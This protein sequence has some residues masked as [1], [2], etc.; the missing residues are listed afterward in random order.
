MLESWKEA[1]KQ[2]ERLGVKV[3]T[4][5]RVTDIDAEGVCLGDERIAAKT[6][7]WAAGVAASPIARTLGVPLDKA[8]RVLVDATLQVPGHDEIYIVGDL[9]ALQQDGKPVPGVSPAAMQG[10]RY[11]AR[12]IRSRLKGKPVKPFRYLDKGT[13]ATIGRG[14]AVGDLFGRLRLSGFPAWLAWLGIH[15]FF[16]VGF[17][18]RLFVFFS[19][20]YSYLSHR[21]GARLITG[22]PVPRLLG[23]PPPAAAAPRTEPAPRE[24]S[25]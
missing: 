12:A 15:I 24:Q 25:R 7:L 9:A 6:V 10:G 20:A 17:R 8:G 21:R 16:L 23:P 11:A 19:W 5:A 13:F 1:Q 18:A 2:L 14:R 22:P 4:G 3:R